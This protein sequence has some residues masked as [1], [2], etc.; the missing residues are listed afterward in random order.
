[1]GNDAACLVGYSDSEMDT[2]KKN[3]DTPPIAGCRGFFVQLVT[4]Y[5]VEPDSV[6]EHHMFK[7]GASVFIL[8]SMHASRVPRREGSG[9]IIASRVAMNIQHFSAKE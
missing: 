3:L 1:M 8:C 2:I 6:H 7:L 9:N 4:L 5:D